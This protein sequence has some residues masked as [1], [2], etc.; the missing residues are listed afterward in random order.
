MQYTNILV[1]V[2]QPELLNEI[3]AAQ[4]GTRTS[5]WVVRINHAHG[6]HGYSSNL[7]IQ[8]SHCAHSVLVDIG[9]FHFIRIHPYGGT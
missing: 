2:R 6:V 7:M 9:L 1:Y 4:V 5:G 3:H 8:S